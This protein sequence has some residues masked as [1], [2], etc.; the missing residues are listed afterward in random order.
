MQRGK[1]HGEFVNASIHE[2]HVLV[3]PPD[4]LD[5]V[6]R[7]ILVRRSTGALTAVVPHIDV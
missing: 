1:M 3:D 4:D 5:D 7:L 6:V 2:R